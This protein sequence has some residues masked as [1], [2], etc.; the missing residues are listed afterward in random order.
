MSYSGHIAEII[1]RAQNWIASTKTSAD[2]LSQEEVEAGIARATKLL[3]YG[4]PFDRDQKN[5]NQ[6][7]MDA[8][9]DQETCLVIWGYYHDYM[10]AQAT[11][12]TKRRA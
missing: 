3:G 11:K 7:L 12:H 4:E 6:L 2:P 8:G 10:M 5:L 9:A 1:E